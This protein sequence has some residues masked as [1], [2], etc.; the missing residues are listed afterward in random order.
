MSYSSCIS[1]AAFVGELENMLEA[2][3]FQ[4]ILIRTKDESRKFVREWAEGTNI[5]EYVVSATIEGVK[6][7]SRDS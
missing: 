2:A 6:P 4:N 7:L 1:G 3:G 5:E